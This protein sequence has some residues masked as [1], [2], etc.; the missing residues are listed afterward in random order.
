MEWY[1]SEEPSDR[2]RFAA[3]GGLGVDEPDEN[4]GMDAL[5]EFGVIIIVFKFE[6]PSIENRESQK[7]SAG[8]GS[9]GT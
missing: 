8:E 4:N 6:W 2:L 9:M 7:C 3:G 1:V 5:E